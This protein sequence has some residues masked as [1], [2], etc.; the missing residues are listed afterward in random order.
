M[1][2]PHVYNRTLTLL[3]EEADYLL[4][5]YFN[6]VKLRPC[7]NDKILDVG[8]GEGTITS[9]HLFKMFP[10]K[11]HTLIGSDKSIDMVNFAN[12]TFTRDG[13]SFRHLD[14]ETESLPI[15][16]K[17]NFDHVFSFNCFQWIE[18]IE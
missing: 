8:C 10:T 6:H 11:N 5:K 18:D 14:I 13:L 16:M 7:G 3:R 15:D 2:E 17:E 4:R 1:F 9:K 12:S